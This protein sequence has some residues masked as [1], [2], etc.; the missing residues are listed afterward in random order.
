MKKIMKFYSILLFTIILLLTYPID[1]SPNAQLMADSDI[2]FTNT[3]NS[4]IKNT[5]VP[6]SLYVISENNMTNAEKTMIATLQGGIASKSE[7][8]IYILSPS[9][10]DYEIWL[11]SFYSNRTA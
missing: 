3:D 10:P 5:I 8:Q 9:E 4:Y 7:T 6:K 11:K 2:N 1:T